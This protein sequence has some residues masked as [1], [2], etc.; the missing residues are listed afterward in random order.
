MFNNRLRSRIISDNI[1]F[2]ISQTA[3]GQARQSMSGII[4]QLA[5][6]AAKIEEPIQQNGSSTK[7]QDAPVI[8]VDL[9]RYKILI[10]SHESITTALVTPQK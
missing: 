4:H 6:L 2:I 10:H 9:E 8:R 1:D 7:K 3:K 5:D